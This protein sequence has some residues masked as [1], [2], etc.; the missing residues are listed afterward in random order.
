M[1]K[2]VVRDPKRCRFTIIH[3]RSHKDVCFKKRC[4][5]NFTRRRQ[6]QR[7]SS[8]Q[9]QIRKTKKFNTWLS[10]FTCVSTY[11]SSNM[12]MALR[13]QTPISKRTLVFC[14]LTGAIILSVVLA[15]WCKRYNERQPFSPSFSAVKERWARG[16]GNPHITQSQHS[17]EQLPSH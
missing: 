4:S 10:T 16:R 15:V 17:S 3:D 2:S 12:V 11:I 6:S 8:W 7:F 1:P 9:Q 14:G 5:L 13:V